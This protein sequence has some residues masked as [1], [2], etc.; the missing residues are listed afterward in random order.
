MM[1]QQQQP[2]DEHNN[3]YPNNNRPLQTIRFNNNEYV[4]DD[5]DKE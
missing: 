2:I 3:L 1:Q 5:L 4:E